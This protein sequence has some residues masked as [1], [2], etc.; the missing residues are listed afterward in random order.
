MPTVSKGVGI[1]YP[2]ECV[3][4][5]ISDHAPEL[6]AN[7]SINVLNATSQGTTSINAMVPADKTQQVLHPQLQEQIF[8]PVTPIRYQV[9]NKLL[10]DHP[11]REKVEY[12]VNGFQFG[13]SLKY[14]GSLE[15]RQSKNLLSAYQYSDKLWASL[16]K[17]VCLGHM[18]GPFPVQPLDP[19][20]CLPVSMVE[21]QDL[22]RCTGSHTSVT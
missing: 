8:K 19:L 1:F 11:N 7:S 9:V 6:S 10:Q 22:E 20:I 18:L 4:T 12:V 13:F 5:S 2:K 21:K 3:M 16:M 14:K 17:E 15:N